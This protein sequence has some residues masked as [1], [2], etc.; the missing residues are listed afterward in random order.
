MS[1]D[2]PDAAFGSDGPSSSSLMENQPESNEHGPLTFD[3]GKMELSLDGCVVKIYRFADDPALP[4]FQAKPV[5]TSLQYANVSC[6]LDKIESDDKMALSDLIQAKGVPIS[7]WSAAPTSSSYNDGK[8]IYVNEYGL[9]TLVL[10]SKKPEAK[11]IQRWLTHEVMPSLRRHGQYTAAPVPFPKLEVLL[12]DKPDGIVA[13]L[14]Q[15]DLYLMLIREVGG[16]VN[17][18]K[19]IWKIG[20]SNQTFDRSTSAAYV[21]KRRDGKH[22]EHHPHIICLD[23]GCMESLMKSEFKETLVPDT[24]EY[25]F[26]SLEFPKQFLAEWNRLVSKQLAQQRIEERNARR[27]LP[28]DSDRSLKRKLDE[29]QYESERNDVAFKAR[30]QEAEVRLL[31][32]RSSAEARRQEAEVSLLEARSAAEISVLRVEAAQRLSALQ[33]AAN[34]HQAPAATASTTVH[35]VEEAPIGEPVISQEH[36]ECI[37][38]SVT[39]AM[40]FHGDVGVFDM[41]TK[42]FPSV[43]PASLRNFVNRCS[44]KVT[45]RYTH[46]RPKTLVEQDARRLARILWEQAETPW[47]DTAAT[48]PPTYAGLNDATLNA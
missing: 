16:P 31:E 1:A 17:L 23:C 36:N 11:A 26:G 8:S 4:W 9:Y 21:L 32:A 44:T 22:W 2:A 18:Q 39:S 6:A 45:L 7:G 46:A 38:R 24:T 10:G 40:R 35:H 14:S 13:R 33:D 3:A 25:F 47:K 41:A 42:L 37:V 15:I 20:R 48:Q 34:V 19:L 12:F 5:L 27:H 29:L 30:R 28:D 43:H